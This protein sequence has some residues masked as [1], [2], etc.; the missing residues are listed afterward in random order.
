MKFLSTKF[1]TLSLLLML[2]LLSIND[3][4]MV[5]GSTV[6]Y[7]S[8]QQHA[9]KLIGI[10]KLEFLFNV[11]TKN[12][13]RDYSASML[14]ANTLLIEAEKQNNIYYQAHA[15]HVLG[16]I[17][18]DMEDSAKTFQYFTR[19][20][21]FAKKTDSISLIGIAYNAI[22]T[23][24][25]K[26][27]TQQSLT[28][29]LKALSI[30]RKTNNFIEIRKV[31]NNIGVLYER[32]KKDY[33]NALQYYQNALGIARTHNDSTGM[34]IAKIN[35][36]D[37]Y[38]KI[39]LL[40]Q[41]EKYLNEAFALTQTLN[42]S[43][44]NEQVARSRAQLYE[45]SGRYYSAYPVLK[46][47]Y[48]LKVNRIEES[49]R[50]NIQELELKYQVNQ[51]T[52]EI[53][54]LS[55]QGS[56]QRMLLIMLF[57][58]SFIIVIFSL[59]VAQ[60]MRRIKKTNELLSHRNKE[61]EEQALQLEKNNIELKE[62]SA[63]A[64]ETDSAVI[65]ANG[66][67]TIQYVNDS[68]VKLTGATYDDLRDCGLESIY[69]LSKNPNIK[70]AVAEAIEKRAPI[71][72]EN[73]SITLNGQ[74]QFGQ[75]TIT[76]IFDEHEQLQRILFIDTDITKLKKVERELFNRQQEL[77]TSIRYARRL[78]KEL[79]PPFK[80]M[81][82]YFTDFLL[83]VR[84]KD[85]VSGD[86]YWMKEKNSKLYIAMADCT[87]H[88]V[89]GAFMSVLSIALLNDVFTSI[90][91][92]NKI[93]DPGV[94]LD[95]LRNRVK[96]MLNQNTEESGLQDGMDISFICIDRIT[97]ML[98]FAGAY[99][100]MAVIRKTENGF[101]NFPLKGDRMPVG[102]HPRCT[103]FN[104]ISIQL[105]P[106]DRLYMFTDGYMIQPG[107]T[108]HKKIGR[109][110]FINLL[111]T[112]QD[113]SMESQWLMLKL[114]LRDWIKDSVESGEYIEQIDDITVLGFQ[115]KPFQE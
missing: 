107:G 18:R 83:F 98:T 4:S 31:Y 13:R 20:L 75:T 2:C 55:S 21:Y 91:N 14:F 58:I 80:N 89:P 24:Y 15:C 112:I 52:K 45:K 93:V 104:T 101:E 7:D 102:I 76:P 36:G 46:K 111:L 94:L 113:R 110:N 19:S 30:Q 106:D 103:P 8:L 67:G 11:S 90:Y 1:V 97:Q 9:Q 37:V 74:T 6:C 57:L 84:P 33:N 85:I 43:Y 73:Q 26:I 27:N 53:A 23:A 34:A 5:I 62:L 71:T 42:L 61:I 86:F 108:R 68:F 63:V 105:E 16:E 95:E 96:D 100:S 50:L 60:Q 28:Y 39:G 72:I 82:S 81:S 99:S 56:R 79:L 66:E 59:I 65:I 25:Q 92:N 87:G 29:F 77:T 40:F 88:G 22:G 69:T 115:L 51:K 32:N 12:I 49:S 54:T 64:S 41:S 17:Y 78:Q 10:K 3:N 44:L 70:D 48:E 47:Y 114:F 109:K 38:C 35:I